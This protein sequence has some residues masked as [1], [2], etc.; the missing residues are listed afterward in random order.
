MSGLKKLIP[1]AD[2]VLIRRVA[3]VTKTASGILL[4]E[5]SISKNNEGEV[6]AVG[7][8]A[9]TKAGDVI[10]MTVAVGDNV[11]LPEYGGLTVK[12]EGE[13]LHLFRNDEIL[14]KLQ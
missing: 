1:L 4:P 12:V 8:G 10:P 6:L 13:E 9:V 7:P 11:L 14:A 2:R 5:S 3:P